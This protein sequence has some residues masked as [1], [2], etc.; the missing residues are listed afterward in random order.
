MSTINRRQFARLAAA[1]G[2]TLAFGCRRAARSSPAWQERRDLYPQGVASGDPTADSVLLWT[3]RPPGDAPASRV[4]V[5]VAVDAAFKTRVAEGSCELSADADWTCRFLAAALKPATE[6]WYRFTDE[7]GYGSR[8]GRTVTAPA[9]DDPRAVR[10]AFVSCQDVTQGACNAWRRMV[11]EDQQRAAD[12]RLS[13]VLHLGDFIYEVTWYSQDR[14]EGMYGRRLRDNLRYP[15]G[16]RIRDFHVPA[17]LDDYRTA[18]RT[19]LQD[20]DLQDARAWFPF[21]PVW[22]NHEFSWQGWQ[23][24]QVFDG[25]TRPAQTKKLAANQAWFEF[26]PARVRNPGGDGLTR[27][28]APA[29]VDTPVTAVDE[30][31]LGTDPNNL[32]AVRSLLVYRALRFGANVD[33]LITDNRSFA[34]PPPALDAFTPQGYRWVTPQEAV[35][36]ADGGRAYAGGHPP[37]TIRFGGADVPNPARDAPPRSCLGVE[38]KAWFLKTLQGATAAW[39]IWGHS[40]GNLVWRSDYQN[41][42]KGLAPLPWPGASYALFNGDNYLERAEILDLVRDQRITGFAVVAGDK[43]SFWAGLLSKALPP[44]KFEP[45]SV[46]FITGSISA[47]GLFE[48]AEHRVPKDD[49]LRPLFLH[50]AADGKLLPAMNMTILHGVASSLK[51]HETGDVQQALAVSN[52]EVSPHL[53]FADLG[54]HGFATVRATP[55]LLEVEFV[56]IPRPLE[57]A[58]TPDGGPLAYRVVHRVKRW[59]AGEAPVIEQQIVEGKPPLAT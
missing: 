1:F 29:V 59:A 12:D 21:V 43:H 13:F 49:P 52:P 5:E 27:F 57:R 58:T 37:A 18:Y 42:P 39:K 31:G 40:F 51:L 14:P 15:T 19:Y 23:S 44:D 22:D 41:L 35:E 9:T 38:Q 16:E 30:L 36:I 3:R 45:V 47:P 2:A 8:V 24:Q 25:K 6:Y 54:G 46:E 28:V 20:P 34:P 32:A 4:R 56:A 33:L 55:E 10:F 17:T 7:A 11:H 26:Q 50:E 48:V 53:R